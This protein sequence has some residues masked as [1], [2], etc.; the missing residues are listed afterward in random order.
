MLRRLSGR[1]IINYLENFLKLKFQKDPIL[2]PLFF[3]YYANLRCNFNCSYCGYAN[4]KNAATH[5]DEPDSK[6]VFELM[7]IIKKECPNIY[8]TGGEPLLRND[9]VSILKA[10]QKMGFKLIAINTNM[11]LIHKNLEVL[12]YVTNLI[13]SLDTINEDKYAEITGVPISIAK[14]VKQNVLACSELQEEKDFIMI[15]NCVVTDK[16]VAQA[17]EV[18]S[19]CFEHDIQFA[20]VPAELT[21]RKIDPRLKNHQEYQN[22]VQEIIRAK[23]QGKPVFNSQR[24]LEVIRDFQQFDCYP[25]LTPHVYPNGDLFYPCKPMFHRAANLLKTK[26]YQQ[27]LK[28]GIEENNQALVCQDGICFKACYIE[29]PIFVKNPLLVIKELL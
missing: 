6:N 12:D 22:F 20:I 2:K 14:Q 25:T 9:I 21:D 5:F 15:I 4:N 23:K 17:R 13:A 19:F 26:S 8:L 1:L 24:Y 16:T 11:S 7:S 18:M 28:I 29:P 27:A 10:C 3:T